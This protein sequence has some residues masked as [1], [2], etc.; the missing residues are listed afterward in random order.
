ME[1]NFRDHLVYTTVQSRSIWL[2]DLPSC[3][4]IISQETHS[5]APLDSTFQYLTTFRVKKRNNIFLIFIFNFS[6]CSL[7]SLPIILLLGTCQ[8]MSFPIS[9]KLCVDISFCTATRRFIQFSMQT[10]PFRGSSYQHWC[11]WLLCRTIWHEGPVSR[12]C[13]VSSSS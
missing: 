4:F 7:C 3:V 10:R 12:L 5:I 2:R 13:S 9:S 1:V 8:D 11:E 6:C